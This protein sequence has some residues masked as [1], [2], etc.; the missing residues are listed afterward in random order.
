MKMKE[1]KLLITG[2]IACPY[3]G[4]RIVIGF[5]NKTKEIIETNHCAHSKLANSDGDIEVTFTLS[6]TLQVEVS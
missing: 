1:A 5:N 2:S 3:C 6:I 4:E